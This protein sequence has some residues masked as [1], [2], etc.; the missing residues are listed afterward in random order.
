MQE[1]VLHATAD[2]LATGVLAAVG[3][4]AGI[5]AQIEE[6]WPQALPPDELPSLISNHDTA[7]F[8]RTATE[9][10]PCQAERVVEL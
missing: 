3:E 10:L 1:L 9:Q 8:T 6:L 5:V 2:R 4:F 7:T